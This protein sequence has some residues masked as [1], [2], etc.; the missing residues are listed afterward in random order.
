MHTNEVRPRKDRRG[1]DLISVIGIFRRGGHWCPRAAIHARDGHDLQPRF[2]HSVRV[3]GFLSRATFTRVRE[4]GI[5]P[6]GVFAT[7]HSPSTYPALP[8]REGEE[9]V[10]WFASFESAEAETASAD[11]LSRSQSWVE[12][13]PKL[14]KYLKAPPEL[15]RLGPTGGSSLR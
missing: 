13:N 1:F 11:R 4:A 3:F 15:L 12:L 5:T 9:V 6:R 14:E 2:Q 10:V 8:L 7:E